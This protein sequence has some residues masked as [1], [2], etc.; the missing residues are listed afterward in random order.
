MNAPVSHGNGPAADEADR[1]IPFARRAWKHVPPIARRPVIWLM[2]SERLRLTVLGRLGVRDE[3]GFFPLSKGGP[4]AIDAAFERL[5]TGRIEGDYYEFGLYR[6]YTF[7][8]AQQ[9]ANRV[10]RSSMRFFGFD[11]FEGLPEVEGADRKAG[12]F[13]SGDYRCTKPAVEAELLQQGFDWDRAALIE[14]YF[15]RS[16]TPEVKQTHS[17]GK[18]ALVLVDCDLYQSTVPVLAFLADLLQDGTIVLFDDWY[19]FDSEDQ[20]EPRAF[21][22]FLHA[23]PEWAADE[24]SQFSPYGQGFVIRSVSA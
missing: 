5:R 1:D 15:D 17:M 20:G 8:Y 23:H 3:Q 22:E 14:G 4:Q 7:W 18:A 16:L 11:S 9:A 21:R 24:L 12:I 6:G 19:C 10:G 13:V 2:R